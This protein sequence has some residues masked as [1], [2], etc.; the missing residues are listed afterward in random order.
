MCAFPLSL[1][2]Q[3]WNVFIIAIHL[4]HKLVQKFPC[5]YFHVPCKHFEIL[6]CIKFEEQEKKQY[7]FLL[8]ICILMKNIFLLHYSCKSGRQRLGKVWG[9]FWWW[10]LLLQ[11]PAPDG[12]PATVSLI[13]KNCLITELDPVVNKDMGS[14]LAW[15]RGTVQDL[16][17]CTSKYDIHVHVLCWEREPNLWMQFLLGGKITVVR[18]IIMLQV[19][20]RHY[21]IISLH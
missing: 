15:N 10:L 19:F 16:M 9:Q 1:D 3:N 11:Q 8:W 14:N 7:T 17:R 18:D 5:T 12:Q 13:H 21:M 2:L 4:F 20:K 6:Y